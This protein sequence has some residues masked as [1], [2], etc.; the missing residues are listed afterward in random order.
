[1]T[2][3]EY[4]AQ[5]VRKYVVNDVAAKRQVTTIYPVIQ[6]WGNTYLLEAIYSGSMA[7]GTGISLSTDADVF[8]SVS[9]TTP[10]TLAEM[11]ETLFNAFDQAGY[12]PKKQNVSIGI[13]SNGYKIDL[14]P[15]KRQSQYGYDHSIW[16]NKN[17]TWT[18]TN[19]KTHVS[20]VAHSNRLTEIKVMKIWRQ[21]HN[22]EFPSFYLELVVIDCLSRSRIGDLGDNCWDV[23]GFLADNFVDAQYTDPA[24]S[25]NIISD[26]L[27]VAEKKAIRT[28]AIEARKQQYWENIVW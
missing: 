3:D 26:D 24:N 22:L 28:A 11:Y 14:V 7:K 25:E 18:K 23:L 4:L 16:K 13:T 17:K 2:A 19:V 1:M 8:I 10:G 9:S 20:T 5:I 27:I 6:T 21:L 15:G 12:N